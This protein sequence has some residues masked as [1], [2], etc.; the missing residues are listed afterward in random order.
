MHV[1]MKLEYESPSPLVPYSLEIGYL[2]NYQFC[3]LEGLKGRREKLIN[4]YQMETYVAIRTLCK[5][6]SKDF[7]P[8]I[9]TETMVSFHKF[10]L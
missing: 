10:W 8:V 5:P 3:E 7:D 6:I 1:I 2:V 9:R 4:L